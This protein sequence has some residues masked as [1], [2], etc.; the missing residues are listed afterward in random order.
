[1]AATEYGLVK[2]THSNTSSAAGNAPCPAE[3]YQRADAPHP[4]ALARAPRPAM[5][6]PHRGAIPIVFVTLSD[7]ISSGRAASLARR[8]GNITGFTFVESAMGGKWVELL[9]EIAPQARWRREW[10]DRE[11]RPVAD[12][13]VLLRAHR[14]CE[15]S[16]AP[17]DG[18]G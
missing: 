13:P 6:Q 8:G 11:S 9:K 2:T 14:S 1:M 18:I 10:S 7:P 17:P 16:T 5:Q 3:L 4:L 15:F 12:R